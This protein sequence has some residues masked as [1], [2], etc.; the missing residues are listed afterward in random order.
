MTLR[1]WHTV[2]LGF[3]IVATAANVIAVALEHQELGPAKTRAGDLYTPYYVARNNRM[4][5]YINRRG[6]QREVLIVG[7]AGIAW[8]SGW[9]SATQKAK[10]A[11]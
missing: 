8:F 11:V 9:F 2:I 7:F 3:V 4:H 10:K 6:V 1:V 5:G